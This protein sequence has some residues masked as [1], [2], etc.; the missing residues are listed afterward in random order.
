MRV[1]HAGLRGEVNHAL[2]LLRA[3]TARSC[4]VL[5]GEIDLHEPET[6]DFCENREPRLLERDVVVLVE[7]VEP[8]DLVAAL[9]Q[10]LRDV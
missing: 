10:V 1:A 8:D 7:V 5:I 9:E 2:E 3:R 6:R 4:R